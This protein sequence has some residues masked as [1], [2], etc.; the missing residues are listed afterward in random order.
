EKQREAVYKLLQ[1]N[2]LILTGKPGTGKTT[3][4]RAMIQIYES[5]YPDN[6]IRLSAPT[7]RASRKMSEASGR[8]SATVHSMLGYRQGEIPEHNED[9]PLDADLVILDEWSMA[10][11]N[12]TYWLMTALERGTKVVFIGDIDQ[13][14]SVSPGSVLS[15]FIQAELPTVRLE[16]I[17]RQAEE[18]QI[19]Q[20]AHR[21]N[22]GKSLLV[23]DSKSDFYF[24]QQYNNYKIAHLIVKSA[25]RFIEM[26]Y[27]LEDIMILSPMRS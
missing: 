18:S 5:L 10:D 14:P 26:G 3:T 17:F 25:L 21:I 8:D 4:L 16:Q 13:L 20:N 11:L 6:E 12:L 22:E 23:D 1:E 2:V 24:I 27:S 9:N 15:D 7:G 19:V